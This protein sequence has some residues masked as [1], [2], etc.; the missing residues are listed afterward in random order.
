MERKLEIMNR[1]KTMELNKLTAEEFWALRI[2]PSLH[3]F[4]KS[5]HVLY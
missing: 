4:K 3:S 2:R 1:M 5:K